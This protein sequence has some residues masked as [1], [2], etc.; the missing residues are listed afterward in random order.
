MFGIVR[1]SPQAHYENLDRVRDHVQLLQGDLLDQMTLLDAM[2]R[3]EPDELYN[4][5]ATSFVP[6]SWRQPVMTA[7]FTATGVTFMLEAVRI[8]NPELRI[9]QASTSEIFGATSESPQNETTPFRPH[10]PYGV[11]KLYGHLMV[12]TY[13]ERYGMHASS[14]ILYNHES[15]R[16]PAEFV[17]R[18]VTRTAAAIKLGLADE[19]RVGDLNATRDWSYAGDVVDAMRLMLQQPEGDDYVVCSGVSR[20][21]RELVE[22]AFA[23]A[24]IEAIS[25]ATSS[26]IRSSS[27]RPIRWRSSAIRARRAR[28]SAGRRG[29]RFD[30]MIAM[31]VEED[32]RVLSAERDARRSRTLSLP[33]ITIVTAALNSE[34]TI[35]ETLRSVREQAY[36]GE[37]EHVVVDGGSTDGTLEIVRA[38]GLRFVSEPDRG[39]T[40]ALNKGIAMA[41]GEIVGS[42]NS[43]DTYLPGALAR[44]GEAFAAHPEVEW[45]TGRCPIVDDRGPGDPARR[46]ALQGGLPAPPLVLA[47]PRPQ[48]RLG[49]GDVR[50]PQ[51]AAGGRRLRRA[52]PLLGRLRHVAEARPPRRSDRARRRRWRRSAWRASRCR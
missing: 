51:R 33:S 6:A 42:L 20:S 1:G 4:L 10:N 25:T 41:R 26:S 3:A 23:A 36:A 14:G 52:L 46:D 28:S 47:A 43:D 22:T 34:R 9:Y 27:A 32:L 16:R 11:A 37:L 2:G 19:L 21:V 31:M 7:Q 44:V 13:R 30:E 17:T 18:K 50:A 15:P 12:A 35:A 29:P 48:L 38:A 49:A 5:A 8:V 39:L 45:V 24:E 40:D